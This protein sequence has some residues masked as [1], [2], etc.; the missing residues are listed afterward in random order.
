MFKIGEFSKLSMVS[1]KTLRYYDEIGLFKPAKIDRFSGYRYYSASQLSRLNRILALKDLGL[2]LDQIAHLLENDLPPAEIRGMLRLKQ[3]EIETQVREEQARLARVETRLRQIEQ[4]G[5]MP[6]QEIVLKEIPAQNVASVREVLPNMGQLGGL[7]EELF[8]YL[9]QILLDPLHGAFNK[10]EPNVKFV[11]PLGIVSHSGV[12]IDNIRK[13]LHLV[14][15]D[16]GSTQGAHI[17]QF[18]RNEVASDTTYNTLFFQSFK[19]FND[20]FF[21]KAHLFGNGLKRA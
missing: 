14:S 12:A 4:E 15:R 2:S 13:Q 20:L 11:I 10:G 19:S 8:G 5:I 1:T 17:P 3:V 9:G 21:G 7:Y 16:F 18:F 6:T